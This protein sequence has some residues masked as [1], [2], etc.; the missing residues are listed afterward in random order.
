MKRL[1]KGNSPLQKKLR[2]HGNTLLFLS[3]WLGVFFVFSLFPIVY[4]F[5]LSFTRFRPTGT[6]PPSWVGLHN[7][8]KLMGDHHFLNAL[9]NSFYFVIG[10]VP[11][12]MIIATFLAVILNNKLRF[13]TFYRVSYFMPVVTSVFVIATIFLELYAPYGLINK[14]LELF[15]LTGKHWL[16]DV[17]WALESIMLMNIWS[18]FGFYTLMILAGLQGIPREYYE[19][20]SL[21]GASATRQFF[22]ITLPLLKPTLLVATLIDTILAFQV[23][24]EMFIMTKGGP[25]RSTESA[26]YYL[27]NIAFHKQRMGY[28]SAAAY[29]IFLIL[30]LFSLFQVWLMRS[31]K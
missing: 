18:S 22:T 20:S 6:K 10:T 30:L 2:Y 29:V 13:R 12:I 1:L 16:R 9:W 15:G 7:Y 17:D 3:P 27:Y 4:S 14:T 8:S 11:A 21:E 25:L 19:A 23:F 31:K 26:V 24:G 28:G 5:Y